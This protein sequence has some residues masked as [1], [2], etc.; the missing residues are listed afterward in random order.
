[1]AAE[2]NRV[3]CYLIEKVVN[4]IYK[5][6]DQYQKSLQFYITF[7]NTL[8]IAFIST[9]NKLRRI[10][11]TP[12]LLHTIAEVKTNMAYDSLVFSNIEKFLLSISCFTG[13]E[14]F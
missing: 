1:M 4:F 3:T 2:G 12:N 5:S 6:K 7:F 10:K 13:S 14:V 11:N 8:S 9:D